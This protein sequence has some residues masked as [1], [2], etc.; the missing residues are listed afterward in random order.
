[1]NPK[2]RKAN[3]TAVGKYLPE[4]ILSNA[5]LEKMV[6]TNDDKDIT[7]FKYLEHK[8]NISLAIKICELCGV[9]KKVALKGMSLCSHG[10]CKL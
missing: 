9:D 1:M 10:N 7:D 2:R 8:E 6:D 3:I 5:D 4:N